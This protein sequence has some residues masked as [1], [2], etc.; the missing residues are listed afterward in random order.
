MN[1]KKQTDIIGIYERRAVPA[2]GVVVHVVLLLT[3]IGAINALFPRKL[4]GG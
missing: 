3:L 2:I 4:S 1:P